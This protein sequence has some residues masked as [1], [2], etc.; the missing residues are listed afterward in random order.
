MAIQTTLSH[1]LDLVSNTPCTTKQNRR[2]WLILI[3]TE[4]AL[5]IAQI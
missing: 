4:T 3:I 1:I 2:I 5:K